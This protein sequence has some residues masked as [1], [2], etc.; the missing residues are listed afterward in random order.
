MTETNTPPVT[1][2]RHDGWY[3][4]GF[5]M[6]CTLAAGLAY[7]VAKGFCGHEPAPP[8][9]GKQLFAD[10]PQNVKPEAVIILSGQTFGFLQPCG[11]SHPQLGGLERRANFMRSLRERGWPVVGVDLGDLHP[12]RHPIGPS[13]ITTPPEQAL[14]KYTVAM[15]ALREMGYIAVGIGKTEFAAG[16]MKVLGEYAYQKDQLPFVLG[17]NVVGIANDK[18][19]P[20]ETYFQK[21][22]GSRPALGLAEVFDVAGTP[23]GVAGVVGP[24]VAK[25]AAKADKLIGFD[26]NQA[27]LARA[28]AAFAASP[29]KPV[30]NILLYEGTVQEAKKL[31]DDF[32]QFQVILCQADDSEP[33]QFP[34][35][36]AG[37]RHPQGEQTLIVEVGHKGRFVGALGVFK[38]PG[39][40]VD[41]RYQLVPLGEEYVTP[42]NPADEK[43]NPVLPLLEQYAEH[44]RDQKLLGKV[45][46]TPHSA[47][48]QA[49]AQNLTFVGS[50]RCM[51][52]HPAE[53]K[54]WQ[55]T[56]H[57]HALDTLEK[58]AKRPGLR[59]LDGECVVCHTVGFGYRT[60]YESAEKTPFLKHV[61][62]ENCHGPGSGHAANPRAAGLLKLMSPW[63]Q[64]AADHLPDTATFVKLAEMN[65]V[66]RGKIAV[67][68]AQQRVFNAVSSMCMKCH[69]TEN[70]PHF[71]LYTY[72][73]KIAHTG[74]ANG[75]LPPP[76]K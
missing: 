70:D 65:P 2:K 51:A 66:E 55:E 19:V 29:K 20:R 3:A 17:G 42:N 52:C 39:G 21:Q 71:D 45:A 49:A 63:K 46:R 23:I 50:E 56:R 64:E 9:G 11:C 33:P 34:I 5:L 38:K 37:P 26:G 57:G 69:D 12:S 72:W 13:Q 75:G 61:G 48:I 10:W 47:Q 59:N 27:V 24:G 35:R 32:P 16:L 1:P 73:P 14:M 62:C 44:V 40:G 54:K 67:P 25:E 76:R 28:V 8:A 6:C 43:A 60:G 30:V 15:N 53:Y 4:A 7:T 58:V 36:H 18:P 41:L 22:P 68:A 74:L 31:A